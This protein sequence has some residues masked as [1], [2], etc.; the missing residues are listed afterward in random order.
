MVNLPVSHRIDR[1]E[2][3][4]TGI[5]PDSG[6]TGI[7]PVRVAF[8]DLP[9]RMSYESQLIRRRVPCFDPLGQSMLHPDASGMKH[10]TRE[11]HENH[12]GFVSRHDKTHGQDARATGSS[13]PVPAGLGR[14]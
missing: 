14:S 7:L 6:G 12:L 11:T 4:G 8:G 2:S 3:S 10:G 5:L 1:R 13:M 9:V